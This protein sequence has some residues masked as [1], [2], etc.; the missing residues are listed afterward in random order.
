MIKECQL[1][2]RW[3]VEYVGAIIAYIFNTSCNPLMHMTMTC[4]LH[5]YKVLLADGLRFS[6]N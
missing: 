3:K 5:I 1:T 6:H 4:V 2:I